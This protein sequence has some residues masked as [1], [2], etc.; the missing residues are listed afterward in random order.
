MIMADYDV[1][2]VGGGIGGL[3]AALYLAKAGRRVLICEQRAEIGGFLTATSGAYGRMDV[4]LPCLCSQGVVFPVLEELGLDGRQML[5]PADWQIAT[6]RFQIRLDNLDNIMDKLQVFFPHEFRTLQEYCKTL[7]AAIRWLKDCFLPHPL[8]QTAGRGAGLFARILKKPRISAQMAGLFY[9]NTTHFLQRHFTDPELIRVLASLGYP[10]MPALLHAGM[11]YLFLEDYWLPNSGLYGFAQLL[12]NYFLDRG[13]TIMLQT[14]VKRIMVQTGKA[15]GVELENGYQVTARYVISAMDYNTTY[16]ILLEN[17]V[18]PARFR[19]LLASRM[20]SQS[21]VT[22]CLALREP[23][24]MLREL[25]AVHTFWF[26]SGGLAQGMIIS[27]PGRR[28][29]YKLT[30][31]GLQP[32]YIS[33]QYRGEEYPERLKTRLLEEIDS[34]IPGMGPQIIHSELWHP[35]RYAEEFGA[36]GGASAGWD[37]NPGHILTKGFPGWSS[38]VGNLY[39]AS[40]WVY[41]PGGVPSAML[42]ARQ[43]SRE[44]IRQ[45]TRD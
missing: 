15:Y 22:I 44:I 5:M 30:V 34:L 26:P 39:H 9:I 41:S 3:T 6:P 31:E 11:W 27:V 14:K 10:Q 42:S 8:M 1:I 19:R 40:Q 2:V 37:L 38:P 23:P 7:K 12:A 18:L 32:V 36:F 28:D 21:Y 29:A 24:V 45:G 35:V 13:G 33:C 17:V 16:N 43:V 4:R 25:N 20:P